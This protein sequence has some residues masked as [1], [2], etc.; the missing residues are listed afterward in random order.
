MDVGLLAR[1]VPEGAAAFQ[2]RIANLTPGSILVLG[3]SA[4]EFRQAV[5]VHL[6]EIA[7][8]GEVV[9][10]CRNPPGALVAF[11]PSEDALRQIEDIMDDV[12]VL[13]VSLAKTSLDDLG[14]L[15]DR[16]LDALPEGDPEGPTNTEGDPIDIDDTDSAALDVRDALARAI[17]SSSTERM[18]DD[19]IRSRSRTEADVGMTATARSPTVTDGSVETKTDPHLK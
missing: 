19:V 9:L 5:T 10:I 1:V 18:R 2:A 14:R 8:H 13:Q 3:S 4:L 16:E 11:R 15:S 6:G 7:L 17:P 12:Q